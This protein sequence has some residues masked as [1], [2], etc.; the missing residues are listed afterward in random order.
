M[1]SNEIERLTRQEAI[2]AGANRYYGK[3]CPKHP[4]LNG[5]RRVTSG[6]CIRCFNRY[7]HT[8]Q[9]RRL[10]AESEFY[11]ELL[12]KFTTERQVQQLLQRQVQQPQLLQRLIRQLG[13]HMVQ[14]VF[15]QVKQHKARHSNGG[16]MLAHRPAATAARR[17]SR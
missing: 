14:L 3:I 7:I 5:K 16:G 4:E 12:A 10:L 13:H 1:S 9:Q 15:Q 2:A 11:N 6:H 17:S 8:Q